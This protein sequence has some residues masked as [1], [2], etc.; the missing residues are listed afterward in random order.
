MPAETWK[1]LA[2]QCAFRTTHIYVAGGTA[3]LLGSDMTPRAVASPGFRILNCLCIESLQRR[4]PML[5]QFSET[6]SLTI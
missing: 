6:L 2:V 4:I 1:R 5:V 3:S